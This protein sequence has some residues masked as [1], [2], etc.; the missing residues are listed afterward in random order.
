MARTKSSKKS[1]KQ[2]RSWRKVLRYIVH[3]RDTPEAIA[4]GLAIGLVVTFTPTVGIQILLSWLLAT[5]FNANRMTAI[6]PVWLTNVFTVP[7]TYAFTYWL[8]S[9]VVRTSSESPWTV[10]TALAKRMNRH[11]FYLFH[12]HFREFFELGRDLFVPMMVGG[13]MVGG[14]AA[15][16]AYPL[17]LRWIYR[18]RARHTERIHARARILSLRRKMNDADDSDHPATSPPGA[19]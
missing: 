9:H 1:E 2:R 19:P 12:R 6:L 10:M 3:Q 15:A 5:L 4:R 8:G 14:V 17:T 16:I 11:E 18:R 13:L 7:P